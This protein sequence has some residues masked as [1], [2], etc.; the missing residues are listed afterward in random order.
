LSAGSDRTLVLGIRDPSQVATAR[1][2]ATALA[3][4]LGF[5]EGAAGKVAIVV[6]ELATNLLKHAGG[7]EV[8]VKAVHA[9]GTRG[10]EVL[11]LDR[12]GGIPNVA[13]AL[14][15]GFSTAGSAGTGLGAVRRLAQV[16]EVHTG[17]SRGTAL[18][19]RI[20]PGAPPAANGRR[21]LDV[22]GVAIPAPGEVVCGDAWSVHHHDGATTLLMADGL[23]HGIV[24]SDAARAAVRVFHANAM[25]APARLLETIHDGLRATRGAAVAVAQIEPARDRVRY[26]GIGNIAGVVLT[27][28][29]ARH[30]VSHNGIV[31]HTVWRIDEFTYPWSCDALLVLHTD[32][33]STHWRLDS[34]P[35]LAVRHPALVAGVLYRDFTR[36]RDDV[37]VVVAR[38]V[39]A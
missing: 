18:F 26:A 6:T 2:E 36:G 15:D 16:F 8:V 27:P 38:E 32:G 12:G 35:G 29:G 19:V 14:E 17:E 34:Y 28:E 37:S 31:G 22:A 4:A 10:M 21:E 7:G 25:A 39:Q 9:S 5:D 24:A 20:W 13:R 1:R 23:G 33:L 30:M 3:S 11:G